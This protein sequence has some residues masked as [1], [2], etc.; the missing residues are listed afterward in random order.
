MCEE[1]FRWRY[2]NYMMI[3][4]HQ[5]N[6][7]Q[8]EAAPSLIGWFD[9]LKE[10]LAIASFA[11]QHAVPPQRA[12]EGPAMQTVPNVATAVVAMRTD[13]LAAITGHR[14]CRAVCRTV[15]SFQNCR[16]SRRPV[17]IVAIKHP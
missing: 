5:R 1:S 12:E 9:G 3:A 6:G 17:K 16:R 11:R 13:G 10:G 7:G 8:L 15:T 14:R 2:W 4:S